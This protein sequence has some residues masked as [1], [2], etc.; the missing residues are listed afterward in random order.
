MR[1]IRESRHLNRLRRRLAPERGH[2]AQRRVARRRDRTPDA[3]E[4]A[5]AT[6]VPEQPVLQAGHR[7]WQRLLA[8]RARR[9]LS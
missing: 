5:A 1:K 2:I 3:D 8:R 6:R 7:R 4:A 9:E